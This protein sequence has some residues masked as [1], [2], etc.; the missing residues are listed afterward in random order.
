MI[1]FKKAIPTKVISVPRANPGTYNIAS[2]YPDDYKK[3]TVDNFRI[4]AQ[5]ANTGAITG[6]DFSV[7]LDCRINSYN[8]QTGDVNYTLRFHTNESFIS[9]A[10]SIYISEY[11]FS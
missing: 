9:I 2:L 1:P 6:Q 10:G 3:F 7:S 5:T 8:N 4:G 11:G